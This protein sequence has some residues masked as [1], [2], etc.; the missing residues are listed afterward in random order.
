[1]KSQVVDLENFQKFDFSYDEAIPLLSA[2]Y[3][4]VD[5]LLP[6]MKRY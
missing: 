2:A 6:R 4:Y 3:F 5:E 1:M